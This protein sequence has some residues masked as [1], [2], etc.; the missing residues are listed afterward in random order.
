LNGNFN[1]NYRLPFERLYGCTI[2][3]NNDFRK[4]ALKKGVR[5]I[6]ANPQVEVNKRAIDFQLKVSN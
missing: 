6:P 5:I 4:E 3:K 2:L 1:K